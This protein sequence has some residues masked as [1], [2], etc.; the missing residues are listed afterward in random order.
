MARYY[1]TQRPVGP[2][3]YPCEDLAVEIV[4][5]ESR[6][7]VEKIGR[8]AWGY[9]DYAVDLIP[10][11]A[12]TYEMVKAGDTG[13]RQFD[14]WI[15]DTESGFSQPARF[16]AERESTARAMARQY[17]KAFGLKGAEITKIEEVTEMDRKDMREEI[18]RELVGTVKRTIGEGHEVHCNV[19]RK[20][21]GVQLQA[22]N[23]RKPENT[24]A[25]TIY[26]DWY[27]DEIMNESMTIENAARCIVRTYEENKRFMPKLD[28]GEMNDK[29]YIL[30]HVEYQLVNKALNNE[31]IAAAP[32][33]DLLDFAALYRVVACSD[34]SIVGSYVMYN[35]MLNRIGISI[36]EL[37]EAAARNTEEIGFEVKTIAE[38]MAEIMD[39]PAGLAS[40]T[41]DDPQVFVLTNKRRTNGSTVLMYGN[42]L[43]EL[44]DRIDDDIFIL[45]SSIH[46]VLAVPASQ[47]DP[48]ELVAMVRDVNNSE[49]S[50]EEI[51]GYHVYRYIQATGEL[52]VA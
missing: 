48:D 43:Q 7:Y 34:E 22:I 17:I 4:N 18:V 44:S 32:H 46:E 9:V 42:V 2:G 15:F 23:I 30:G 35:E 24:L 51:L 37:D 40:E 3:T 27:A 49:V 33:K 10:K 41:G 29:E 31:I 8:K 16:K 5:F 11:V 45:P 20:N 25:T 38:I 47:V 12:A 36:E 52:S 39:V 21:N 28:V 50:D 26:I 13:E 1:S 19:V 14:V 6:Q